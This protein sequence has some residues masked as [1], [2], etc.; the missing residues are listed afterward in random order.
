[1]SRNIQAVSQYCFPKISQQLRHFQ[2]LS[3]TKAML[4]VLCHT[5]L[6]TLLRT[7]ADFMGDVPPLAGR[8]FLFF[9]HGRRA[10]WGPALSYLPHQTSFSKCT[11]QNIELVNVFNHDYCFPV[12]HYFSTFL[13][14]LEGISHN[15]ACRVY[16]SVLLHSLEMSCFLSQTCLILLGR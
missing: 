10:V 2:R 16:S 12:R 11:S 14:I 7:Y 4:R 15:P 9:P 3:T 5:S 1:M 13:A 8:T 6:V